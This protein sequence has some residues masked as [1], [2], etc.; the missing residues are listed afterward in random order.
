MSFARVRALVVVGLLAVTAV[1]FVVVTLVRDAQAVRVS[2]LVAR[3]AGRLPTSPC[4][5][6][7]RSRSMC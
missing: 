2:P 1:V 7:R 6:P 5:Y 3:T 4:V